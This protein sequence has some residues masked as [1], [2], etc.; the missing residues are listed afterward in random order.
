MTRIQ[1]AITHRGRQFAYV[2]SDEPFEGGKNHDIEPDELGPFIERAV[3]AIRSGFADLDN[4]HRPQ[5][6]AVLCAECQRPWPCAHA[7]GVS[8]DPSTTTE[9]ENHHA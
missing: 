9:K 6:Q 2:A 8:A 4:P 3:D 1:I 5:S 7:G